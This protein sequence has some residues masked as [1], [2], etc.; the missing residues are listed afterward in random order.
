[1]SENIKLIS[2]ISQKELKADCSEVTSEAEKGW[3]EG[4]KRTVIYV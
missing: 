3:K 2:K 4:K 1:M